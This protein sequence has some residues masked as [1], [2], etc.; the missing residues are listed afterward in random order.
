MKPA[1]IQKL[2]AWHEQEAFM[3]TKQLYLPAVSLTTRQR[4]RLEIR[5]R[6]HVRTA[7]VLRDVFCKSEK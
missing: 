6:Q 7:Q 5:H 4:K 3:L 1:G 2:V